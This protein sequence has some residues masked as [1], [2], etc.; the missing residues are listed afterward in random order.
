MAG[1]R[2]SVRIQMTTE[3]RAVTD[4]RMVQRTTQKPMGHAPVLF[5][6]MAIGVATLAL[7]AW[8]IMRSGRT[9]GDD[10]RP[11]RIIA[12]VPEFSLTERD[13]RTVTREDLL[14]TIW[15]AD[16]IFTTCA[17]PCPML[18]LR[19]RSLQQ[20]IREFDQEVKLVSFSVDPEYDRPPIL[21][22]YAERYGADAQRWWFV[23]SDDQGTMYE[24]IQRGFLQTVSPAE[25]GSPIIHSTRFVLVDRMG[26]IRA[27]YD[28]LEASSKAQILRDIRRLLTEPAP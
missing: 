2:T 7:V 11:L 10:Q 17:G 5:G 25:K 26:R 21:R 4:S 16:F 3:R 28:G 14:G 18:T 20:G 24:L 6:A 9:D 22:A 12:T 19:M 8:A 13:G 1:I 23:T 27:V 15:V